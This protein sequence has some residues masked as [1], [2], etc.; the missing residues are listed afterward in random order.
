MSDNEVVNGD[1]DIDLDEQ[2]DERGDR[3][4]APLAA[5]LLLLLLM[6]CTVLSL[7]TWFAGGPQRAQFVAR[8]AECLRCHTEL[9]P[10]FSNASVHAPFATK[11]CGTC[12]T[13]HGKEVR[14]TVTAGGGQ[15]WKRLT[16]SVLWR[17]FIWW[18]D[19]FGSSTTEVETADGQTTTTSSDGSVSQV[20]GADS[21]LVLP[22]E[23]LCWMCHGNLG[24]KLSD[25]Y[26]HQPFG[27]GRCGGCHNPHSSEHKDLLAASPRDLCFTCHPMGIE[28][29][30]KQ[31]HSPAEIGSCIDCHDPH[32]SNFK[33]IIVEAQRELCFRCHPSVA[34]LS[35]MA[36]QH[37]PY[38]NDACTDCHQPHGSDFLPLLNL[39]QPQL[40]YDC[41]AHIEDE[42]AEPSRHPVNIA[43]T[44]GDCHDPHA[45]QYAGLLNARDNQFCY[46]CHGT[47]QARYDASD[48]GGQL[49]VR[50][51]TPHGS[52][53]EPI[54]LARNPDVCLR[55]HES[56]YYDESSRTTYRNNHP[57][58]PNRWDIAAG[59]PLTCTSTCHDP[60]GTRLDRM[61]RVARY[62]LD[63]NCLI[64]H[65]ATPG[66]GVG[67][68]Y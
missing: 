42:F 23:E 11:D 22:E 12:H 51:H 52:R 64:C 43:M 40:C 54:L 24:V 5:V 8:N 57:V 18:F 50:C 67:I 4:R 35:G 31:T 45:A 3:R 68:D 56:Q 62:P 58:R 53:Y 2:G 13:P 48:H 15:L 29:G 37:L 21:Q 28:L 39:P 46:G 59:K 25:E 49:C 19:V 10:E 30:R 27:V 55:C 65:R 47:L 1:V 7:V 34:Q 66:N 14:V 41:H 20:K 16:T 17:P 63:A 38:A 60:H 9:I 44:C 32:A 6:L 33:G 26:V 61:L 36:V